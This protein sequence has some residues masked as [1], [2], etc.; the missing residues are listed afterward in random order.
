MTEYEGFDMK[1]QQ[2][3]E[4]SALWTCFCQSR[5]VCYVILFSVFLHVFLCPQVAD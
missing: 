1:K 5:L 2:L 3:K 4:K